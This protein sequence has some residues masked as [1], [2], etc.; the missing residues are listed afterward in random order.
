[1]EKGKDILAYTILIA[2]ALFIIAALVSIIGWENVLGCIIFISGIV[3]L[4]WAIMR[5]VEKID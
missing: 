4:G 3:I 2:C 5:I 1:M